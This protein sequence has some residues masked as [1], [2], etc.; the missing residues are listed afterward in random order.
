MGKSTLVRLFVEKAKFELYEINLERHLEL[1]DVF[2][3]MDI[4]GILHEL[5]PIVGTAINASEGILFLDEI[6]ATPPRPSGAT[7]FFRRPAAVAR[8]RC[9][10]IAGIRSSKAHVLDAGGTY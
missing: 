4:P 2:K 10:F 9:G 5:E 8:N 1:D 6:Q 3:T 7:L